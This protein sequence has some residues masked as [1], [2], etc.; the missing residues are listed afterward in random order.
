MA[1]Y[2]GVLA[3]L[4]AKRAALDRERERLNTAIA[5]IEP[6]VVSAGR[7][8]VRPTVSSRTFAGLNMP[9]ALAK[10]AK[11]AQQPQTTGQ[12]TGVLRAGGMRASAKS[13]QNQVYN[14]LRRLSE[15]DGPWLRE[16]D[17]RWIPRVA[18]VAQ[19]SD[20]GTGGALGN[21]TH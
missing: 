19:A 20:V 18:A 11:V 1:D 13:F 7:E 3:D 16:N 4:K 14:I 15:P 10:Y 21:A 17:G 5:A 9:Q 6:L 8:E 12:V 2:E